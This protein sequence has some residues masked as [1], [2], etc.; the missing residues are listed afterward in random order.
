MLKC[1]P[2]EDPAEDPV[3]YWVERFIKL[4]ADGLAPD[5]EEFLQSCP[6]ALRPQVRERIVRLKR[7]ASAFLSSELRAGQTLAGRYVLQRE[8]GRGGQGS[9][10]IARDRELAR[11]VAVKVLRWR[12]KLSDPSQGALLEEVRSLA[13]LNHP[14]VAQLYDVIQ[15]D[16]AIAA[17]MELVGDGETLADQLQA[18][19]SGLRSAG[20]M[21]ELATTL[22][23]AIEGLALA[24]EKGMVHGDV[25]PAN[26][27][28]D[29]SALKVTDFSFSAGPGQPDGEERAVE[30]G[31]CFYAPVEQIRGEGLSPATDVFAAGATLYE[32]I[33]GRPLFPGD[34]RKEVQDRVSR[35]D[36]AD[37]WE[38][39]GVVP[40]DLRA[41]IEKATMR[42]AS[43][44]YPDARG[45]AEDLSA[46]LAGR[47]VA[48]RPLKSPEKIW[49]WVQANPWQAGAI[50]VL[51]AAIAFV[52]AAM[53]KVANKA[54][55]VE[56]LLEANSALLRTTDPFMSAG[57]TGS[58][59]RELDRIVAVLEQAGD[60]PLQHRIRALESLGAAMMSLDRF[61]D[62]A[63]VYLQAI[64]LGAD[65]GAKVR[66]GWC[67]REFNPSKAR[68]ILEP[69]ASEEY[70]RGGG[71]LYAHL[72]AMNRLA[73]VE[74]NERRLS[75]ITRAR[76]TFHGI[77]GRLREAGSE[78][79]WLSGLNLMDLGIA[80]YMEVAR[81]AD[82]DERE[83][84]IEE[85]S[86]AL[87]TLEDSRV[88]FRGLAGGRHP[89]EFY[90]FVAQQY[91]YKHVEGYEDAAILAGEEALRVRALLGLDHLATTID[92][93]IGQV[94]LLES[95]GRREEA[96]ALAL[97]TLD[98]L[99][100]VVGD[101]VSASFDHV[102]AAAQ[103]LGLGETV[104]YRKAAERVAQ[105]SG[106]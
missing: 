84:E 29:G 12:A 62:A 58:I 9:V 66:Y 11:E 3:G 102:L 98:G 18:H 82:E 15:A 89:E 22:L 71:D 70:V 21:R 6:E 94:R 90:I 68:E 88:V 78:A 80:Q 8:I 37:I 46:W 26:L 75:N 31:T 34:S 48:A 14:N 44:R 104:Q 92:F 35:D 81:R 10:W 101:P 54:G 56:D 41:I 87:E 67:L 7:I 60:L 69:L 39:E 24:H 1:P 13:A 63:E 17:I 40:R 32:L 30:L 2:A 53:T 50:A 97:A 5:L 65:D 64:D 91:I 19:S 43:D 27:L 52:S 38:S 49:R 33:I 28:W 79:T 4:S 25:K 74:L 47:P 83:A 103:R 72:F 93:A 96:A 45:F 105:A 61:R 23:P 95:A 57:S 55:E 51:L 59:S 106:G 100:R 36:R 86:A 73:T 85:F 77:Q 99:G 20:E 16:H 42:L 76:E